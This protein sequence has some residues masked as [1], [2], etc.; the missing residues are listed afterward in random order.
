[1]EDNK[2]IRRKTLF[3]LLHAMT[4][5]QTA[6]HQSLSKKEKQLY[7]I[8]VKHMDRFLKEMH[9]NHDRKI[10]EHE[11][12]EN[13]EVIKKMYKL[14]LENFASEILNVIY[15]LIDE[16]AAIVFLEI[17]TNIKNQL[18]KTSKK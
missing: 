11:T 7:N 10:D 9:D 13:A 18:S 1:M 17:L 12:K 4:M 16:D 8:A 5:E 14:E 6:L 3:I 2:K 15:T